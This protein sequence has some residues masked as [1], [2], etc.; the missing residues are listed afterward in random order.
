[1]RRVLVALGVRDV[2]FDPFEPF[3]PPQFGIKLAEDA[4]ERD[5]AFALRRYVF[6]QE[7]HI[8]ASDDRDLIDESGRATTIV[9]VD[10]IMGMTHRVVGTVRIAE[11]AP[12]VWQGSRLAI[13]PAYRNAY[14]LGSGLIYRAVTTAHGHGARRFLAYVQQ[15]NV[16]LFTRLS[17]ETLET[18]DLHGVPHALMSADLAAYPAALPGARPT[19]LHTRRAS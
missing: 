13:A 19:L 1:M 12:G 4:W 18:C 15:P 10:Y 9:A 14:G 17:W 3:V 5:E 16:A 6:C 2:T 7:Q 8:F 11:T